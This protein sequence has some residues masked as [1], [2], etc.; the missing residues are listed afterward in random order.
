MQ[1]GIASGF[2][3]ALDTVILGI[4][5]S[6]LPFASSELGPIVGASIHDLVCAVAM[7]VLMSCMGRF[8]NVLQALRTPNG[9]IIALAALI[10]G[11]IGMSGYL[12]SINNLGPGYTAV[13]SAIY[14]AVGTALAHFILHEKIT[15]KQIIALFVAIAG[16][17]I[18]G[19]SGD[20]GAG[21]GNTV[22]GLAGALM[23]IFGWGSEAVIL[24]WGMKGEGVDNRVALT[25]REST[26]AL[27]YIVIILPATSSFGIFTDAFTTQST[28]VL[29]LAAC[30]GVAS[31]L[32]YYRGIMKVGA[33]R[34]MAANISYSAWAVLLAI[35]IL[36][37]TPTL[38][39]VICCGLIAF[40]TIYASSSKI[41]SEE[42][43][44]R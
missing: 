14:P 21:Q 28:W 12:I 43:A 39:E 23:C 15:I 7:I 34:A 26:S 41:A 44:I 17:M 5:L 2:L 30:A 1:W 31:Y 29:V 4:A 24:A 32:C 33:S 37:H 25:I 13:L 18:L 20:S 6:Y 36:S 11:P 35:F 8:K 38:V 27:L 10:G 22:L 16:V 3:W 9:R 19:Y 42:D 40:G